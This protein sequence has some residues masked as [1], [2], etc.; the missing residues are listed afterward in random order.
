MVWYGIVEFNVALDT[1]QVISETIL[2]VTWP[3]HQRHITEGRWSVN[4]VKGQ[5]HQAQLTKGKEKDVSTIFF[6]IYIAPLRPKTQRRLG[7]EL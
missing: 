4:Q 6:Y 2:R 3:N 7:R 1:L 5:S